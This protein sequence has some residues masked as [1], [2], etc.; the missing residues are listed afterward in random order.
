MMY[1]CVKPCNNVYDM[2]NVPIFLSVEC[3]LV[4]NYQNN[5]F[6]SIKSKVESLNFDFQFFKNEEP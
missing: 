5:Y 6:K 1:I 2:Y 3:L 4:Y